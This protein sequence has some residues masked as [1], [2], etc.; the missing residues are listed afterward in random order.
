MRLRTLT[1]SLKWKWSGLETLIFR[2]G[3]MP[4]FPFYLIAPQSY[5]GSILATLFSSE[6]IP[7]LHPPYSIHNKH[8]LLYTEQINSTLSTPQMQIRLCLS[9]SHAPLFYEVDES[10]RNSPFIHTRP[11]YAHNQ[12]KPGRRKKKVKTNITH[13]SSPS[14]RSDSIT[15][16]RGNTKGAWWLRGFHLRNALWHRSATPPSAT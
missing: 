7:L 2:D 16:S 8:L 13:H 3:D 12:T 14:E 10:P 11:K 1:A 6:P 4:F 5:V 9:T 15:T